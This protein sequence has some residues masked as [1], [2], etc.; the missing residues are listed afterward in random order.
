MQTKRLAAYTIRGLHDHLEKLIPP[1]VS[2]NAKILDIGCGT[3]AWLDR[4]ANA[5]FYNL[6]GIDKDIQNFATQKA[7][8]SQINLDVDDLGLGNQRFDLITCIEVVE[9]LEN[10][11]HLFHHVMKLLE[12]NGYFLLTTPNLHSLIC[13]LRFLLTGNLR[14]FDNKGNPTH[15]YPVFMMPLERILEN[16]HLTIVDKS[17][18]PSKTSITSR[19]SL[20]FVSSLLSL[21]LKDELPGDTL[22]LL[23]QKSKGVLDL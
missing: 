7:S 14:D 15:I 8:C 13:K 17:T 5:G 22:C 11:G 4:L 9:H 16:H 6:H 21:V 3:G 12:T 1:N 2:Q 19:A 20:K 23:I 10:P 18:Y